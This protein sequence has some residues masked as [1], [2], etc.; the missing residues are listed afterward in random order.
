[1]TTTS[2]YIER[3][4]ITVS[5]PVDGYRYTEDSFYLLDYIQKIKK[6][7]R[8]IDIGA[9]SG[10]LSLALSKK[11]PDIHVH[12]IEIQSN[13]YDILKDNISNNRLDSQITPVNIDYR[14]IDKKF[15]SF[16]DVVVVNPPYRSAG[17]G[18][19]SPN[20][21]KASARHEIRGSL[22]E[23]MTTVKKILKDKGKLYTVYLSERLTDII[24]IM[25]A[26]SIEP[27]IIQPVYPK[28]AAESSFVLIEGVKKGGVGLKLIPPLFRR[29]EF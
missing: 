4:D 18:R 26:C 16:F 12:A 19:V 29:H 10:I 14:L 8:L 11:F 20:A 5:Q 22:A 1:L 23:L 25:R 15:C 2:E 7:T 17:R 21:L 3:F 24:S 9:G 13:L 28:S 27:K 6:K